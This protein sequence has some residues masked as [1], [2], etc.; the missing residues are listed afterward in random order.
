MPHPKDTRRVNGK[1]YHL[2]D[3]GLSRGDAMALKRHLKNTEDK[4]VRTSKAPDG[5][6]VWWAKR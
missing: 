5:Y 3:S 6:Q 1:L 2:E 4:K